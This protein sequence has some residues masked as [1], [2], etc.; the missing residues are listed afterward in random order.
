M[1][2]CQ[3]EKQGVEANLAKITEDHSKKSTEYAAHVASHAA[4]GPAA[5]ALRREDRRGPGHTIGPR[6]PELALPPERYHRI[7]PS[8]RTRAQEVGIP[9]HLSCLL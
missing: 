1:A 5:A 2:F 7:R 9:H 8:A 4:L 6:P 3:S